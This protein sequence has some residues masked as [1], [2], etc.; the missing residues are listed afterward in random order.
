MRVALVGATGLIGSAVA[1]ALAAR[2]EVVGGSRSAGVRVDI[3]DAGSIKAFLKEVGPV[4]AVVCCAGRPRW[5][6]MADLT[7]D[8]Y[9]DSL[10]EKLLGQVSLTRQAISHL[11]DGGAVVL[12]AG[13]LSRYPMPGSTAPATV[14]AALEGFVRAAA[15]EMPRGIRIV[16]VSPG[17]VGNPGTESHPRTPPSEVALAYVEAVE[18]AMTGSAISVGRM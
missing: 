9:L 18:G 2:H 8:D 1:T 3:G 17:R 6:P 7:S 10:R 11:R 13:L 14:N 15:L 16:V 12:T 4:D 5:G